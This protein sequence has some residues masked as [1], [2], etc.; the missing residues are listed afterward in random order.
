[1]TVDY[2]ARLMGGQGSTAPEPPPPTTPSPAP[3]DYYSRLMQQP[4]AQAPQPAANTSTI[5]QAAQSVT[6]DMGAIER[7]TVGFGRGLTLAGRGVKQAALQAAG[8]FGMDTKPELDAMQARETDEKRIFDA[9]VGNTTAGTI[10]AFAGEVAPSLL[11]P[12]GAVARG[13][14]LAQKAVA[15][16]KLGGIIGGLQYVDPGE[17]RLENAAQ[18]A[19]L[20]GI[21]SGAIDIATKA[22]SRLANTITG[23]SEQPIA[24]V[25]ALGKQHNVPVYAPDVAG[26]PITSKVSALAE[27]IPLVGMAKPRLQQ[28]EAAAASAQ[29]MM[30]RL[31]APVNDVGRTLQDSLSSRTKALQKLAGKRYDE[32]AAVADPLGAIPL[33][34]L[35]TT[36]QRLLADAKQD[37]D[38]S[39]AL[40]SRLEGIAST[41]DGA[42]FSQARLYRSNIGDE[43]RK[44]QSGSDLKAAR[45]LQQIKSALEQ[46]MNGF[47]QTA[48]GDVATKWKAADQFFKNR[49]MP[50]RENDLAR[51]MR[52]QNPDE[53]FKQFIKAG[54]QD[55]AQRLYDAL[56]AK[57][58]NAV[59]A[60]I[61]DQAWQKAAQSGANGVAF[62]PAKFAGELE[63]VQGSVGVFFKGADKSEID[64][65][66]KLMRHVQ[67]AGQVAENPPTG[68][69]LILPML[70]GETLAPGTTAAT[71]GSGGLM[72]TLF[73]TEPGKRLLLASNRFPPGHP[74][75]EQAIE[76]FRQKAPA[77]AAPETDN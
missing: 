36:A 21:A 77:L 26:S 43:I 9:G 51:A 48:G 41:A 47:I 50:Q 1:M 60:G 29:A 54:S 24:D 71:L 53:V 68:N 5:D 32:V 25:L 20:G 52:N 73:T 8:A 63:R 12:G 72:R 61:L 34:N 55:R 14:S 45:P 74:K 10:G 31:A 70:M 35:R 22:G 64:G 40:I 2:Y 75:L 23:R 15:G 27:D 49:V 17:S 11:V 76:S 30:G 4:A 33:N 66:T 6:Q 44:L 62:S 38:P 42:N 7:A 59:K 46:D 57:G 39:T 56:G 28:A 69:R 13:A 3:V 19:A 16:A 18:G 65:F 58:R 67:R 37:I